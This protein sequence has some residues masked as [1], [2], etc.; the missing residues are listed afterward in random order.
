MSEPRADL[1]LS[2]PEI[3]ALVGVVASGSREGEAA[4]ER[5]R[6]L[7]VGVVPYL[8]EAFSSGRRWQGRATLLFHAIPHARTSEAA[9][10]LGLQALRDK[11]YMVRYRACMVLAYALRLEAVP[12]LREAAEHPD[13]RTV[14][15]ALAALDAIEH[16]NHHYFVDR[17]HSGRNFWNVNPGDVPAE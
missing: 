2:E 15:D 13:R 8:A 7:R 5:L 1:T 9:F 3:R 16:R 4:W 17:E 11:S 6:S 14:E 12:A 10:Q